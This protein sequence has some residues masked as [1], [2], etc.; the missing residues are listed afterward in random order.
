MKRSFC[1]RVRTLQR[2]LEGCIS[3][4]EMRHIVQSLDIDLFISYNTNTFF[5][6]T[7]NLKDGCLSGSLSFAIYTKI[8][9][10]N[11]EAM[12]RPT[13]F[14]VSAPSFSKEELEKLYVKTI[15]NTLE[16]L[17]FEEDEL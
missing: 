12:G 16:H 15:L 13:T 7:E 3:F 17:N 4:K 6:F 1:K 10:G 14:R 2:R 8:S 9:D 11:H 5:A